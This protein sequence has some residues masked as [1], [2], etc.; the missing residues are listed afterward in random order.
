MWIVKKR[1][2]GIYLQCGV[3]G[4]KEWMNVI[5]D[6]S[7]ATVYVESVATKVAEGMNLMFR[8]DIWEAVKL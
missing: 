6:D 7:K 2:L 4:G 5:H 3:Y 8:T 1:K